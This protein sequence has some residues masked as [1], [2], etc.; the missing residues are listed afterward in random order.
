M[1][2]LQELIKF[3]YRQCRAEQIAL[4]CIAALRREQHP[5]RFG[6]DTL[7]DDFQ[8]Q[9]TRHRNDRRYN[10]GI[11][12]VMKYIGHECLVDFESVNGKAFQV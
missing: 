11:F 7:G 1:M 5:L 2:A 12:A 3:R 10:G 8:I 4:K 9:R 6:F